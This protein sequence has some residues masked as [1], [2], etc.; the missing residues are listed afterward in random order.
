MRWFRRIL[1]VIG[2]LIL[3]H[4]CRPHTPIHE[5][6]ETERLHG[7]AAMQKAFLKRHG[8][9]DEFC[10]LVDMRLPSGKVR[11]FVYDLYKDSIL[12]AGMVA[13][14]CGDRDFSVSP[15]FS[16]IDG[17]SCTAVGR[18]RIGYHYPGQFGVAY[19]LYGLDSTNDQAFKRN[20]VLHSYDAVPENET[21]PYPICN[22]RGCPM[23]SPVF[24]KSL[25]PLIDGSRKP[26]CLWIFD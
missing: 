8:F 15:R 16:N 11:F 22:S 26:V 23:V 20:I 7:Q 21:Y 25:R 6:G 12:M 5:A 17:S 14:G 10:F 13:H 24:L 9:N 18:Y 4:N 3:H 1:L 2:I 19:K